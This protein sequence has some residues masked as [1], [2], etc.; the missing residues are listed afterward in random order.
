MSVIDDV[1]SNNAGF[2]RLTFHQRHFTPRPRLHLVVLT[3]M[4]TRLTLASMGLKEGDAHLIRNAGGIVTTDA[5]RSIILSHHLLGTEEIMVINHTDC[6]LTK[7]GEQELRQH[8]RER[9]NVDA[10]EPAEFQA[11]TNYEENVR[12]QLKRLRSHP[13][14]QKMPSRGFIYHVDTGLL[15][16]VVA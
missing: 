13:W 16:E 11:F 7:M 4:D 12:L 5:L 8:I 6:G 3:C 1:V 10:A 9:T 15:Q 14:L 2:A